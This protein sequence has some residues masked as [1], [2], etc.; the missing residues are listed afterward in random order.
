MTTS[1]LIVINV[2]LDVLVLSAVVRILWWG[3]SADRKDRTWAL[4][5]VA[6]LAAKDQGTTRGTWP[7][8]DA[9]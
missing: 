4:P 1:S 2:V 6:A 3:I 7:G 8:G 5:R 9:A